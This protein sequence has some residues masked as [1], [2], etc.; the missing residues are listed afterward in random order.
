MATS[1]P[2]SSF[3]IIKS[4]SLE[5]KIILYRGRGVAGEQEV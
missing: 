2:K 5:S 3:K 1:I 4:M